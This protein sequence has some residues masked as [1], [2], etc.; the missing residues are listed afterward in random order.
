MGGN[1]QYL[2]GNS[3]YRVAIFSVCVILELE[4]K[5]WNGFQMSSIMGVKSLNPSSRSVASPTRGHSFGIKRP[6]YLLR[7]LGKGPWPARGF[8]GWLW[9]NTAFSSSPRASN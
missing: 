8:G 5:S 6:F 9:F 7:R 3:G 4:L 1:E 2:R